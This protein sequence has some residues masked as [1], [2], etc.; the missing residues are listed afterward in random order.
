MEVFRYGSEEVLVH[1]DA[2][3][4]LVIEDS[5]SANLLELRFFGGLTMELQQMFRG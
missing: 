1:Y 4:R 3:E 5:Q 2:L